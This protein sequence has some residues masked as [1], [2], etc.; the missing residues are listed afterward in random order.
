MKVLELFEV[1]AIMPMEFIIIDEDVHVNTSSDPLQG[2]IQVGAENI[3]NEVYT[4]TV[5]APC[6]LVFEKAERFTPLTAANGSLRKL[7]GGTIELDF[8]GSVPGR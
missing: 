5:P 6:K 1:G 7:V 3:E 2:P 8:I 4:Y